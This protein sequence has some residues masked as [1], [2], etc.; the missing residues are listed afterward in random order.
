M[1]VWSL[2]VCRGGGGVL[3]EAV[4]STGAQLAM[5]PVSMLLSSRDQCV[6]VTWRGGP[7]ERLL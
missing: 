7:G 2:G 1:C 4:N 3:G 5:C 6:C